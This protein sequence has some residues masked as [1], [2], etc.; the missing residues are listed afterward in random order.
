MAVQLNILTKDDIQKYVENV[1]P[2]SNRQA[3]DM[4]LM[5]DDHA[6]SYVETLLRVKRKSVTAQSCLRAQRTAWTFSKLWLRNAA[7]YRVA[8]F[9]AR[10]DYESHLCHVRGAIWRDAGFQMR[11]QARSW[12]RCA[13]N[14]APDIRLPAPR[15]VGGIKAF[16]WLSKLECQDRLLLEDIKLTMHDDLPLEFKVKLGAHYDM[17]ISRLMHLERFPA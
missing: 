12:Q 5:Q 2:W 14:A 1:L 9:H 15:L 11:R 16:G 13:A 7:C 3:V 17:S 6:R 10:S 8:A 4:A